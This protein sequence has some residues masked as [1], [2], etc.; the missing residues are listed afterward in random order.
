[1]FKFS[2]IRYFKKNI[3]FLKSIKKEIFNLKDSTNKKRLKTKTFDTKNNQN[4]NKKKVHF[5]VFDNGEILID[6]LTS[7]KI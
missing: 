3:L 6:N 7:E 2:R 1:M 4:L 5:R